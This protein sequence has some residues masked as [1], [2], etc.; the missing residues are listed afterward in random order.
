MTNFLAD[1]MAEILGDEKKNV[2]I[3]AFARTGCLI[4]LQ[5]RRLDD[6]TTTDDVIKPQ[7]LTGKYSIP[8]LDVVDGS[9]DVNGVVPEQRIQPESI[10]ET[11]SDDEI[12]FLNELVGIDDTANVSQMKESLFLKG[13]TCLMIMMR[14][15]KMNK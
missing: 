14:R 6:G 12:D 5:N 9:I 15:K 13:L 11:A 7:G 2:R 1:A 4:E 3:G 10:E 8:S